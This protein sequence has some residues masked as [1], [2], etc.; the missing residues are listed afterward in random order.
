MKNGKPALARTGQE[1]QFTGATM[2]RLF[3]RQVT[4]PDYADGKV[5]FRLNAPDAQKVMLESE[6]LSAP[7]A[8]TKG[9]DG[10][11]SVTLT[12][13]VEDVF[14]YCF[15]VDGTKIAD[16]TNMYLSPDK[17]FKYSIAYAPSN[18]FDVQVLGNIKF[19]RV[20]YDLN[21]NV[22]YYFPPTKDNPTVLIR[23]IPGADDTMESW[24][25]V[26]GANL[27]ADKLLAQ[28]KTK[29]CAMITDVFAEGDF[30]NFKMKVYTLKASD[31]KTWKERRAALEKLLT[32]L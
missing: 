3:P 1:Q 14:K 11:W 12:N 27:I 13:N 32:N 30:S 29:P 31:Y 18:P 25:K 24:F 26:G 10:V 6:L 21:L 2:A 9:D 22:A 16:P 17:G 8:L 19:G 15:I 7:V 5:T 20:T 28:G 4:S 23:L